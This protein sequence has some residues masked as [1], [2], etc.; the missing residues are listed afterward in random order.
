VPAAV[1]GAGVTGMALAIVDDVE[2]FGLQGRL[3]PTTNKG[4]ALGGHGAT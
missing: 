4:D 3:E 1:A 2:R